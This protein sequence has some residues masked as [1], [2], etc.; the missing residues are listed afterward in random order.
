[1]GYYNW[2]EQV[3]NSFISMLAQNQQQRLEHRRLGMEQGRLALQKQQIGLEADR[4]RFE[5]DKWNRQ[6]ALDREK[7]KE[8]Q[9]GL[10]LQRQIFERQ[11]A[12]QDAEDNAWLGVPDVTLWRGDANSNNIMD[13]EEQ[14]STPARYVDK[15]KPTTF[16]LFDVPSYVNGEYKTTPTPLMYMDA[17]NILQQATNLAQGGMTNAELQSKLETDKQQQSLLGLQIEELEKTNKFWGGIPD[18]AQRLSDTNNDGL[19]NDL[20]T[21]TMVPAQFAHLTKGLSWDP[22][23]LNRFNNGKWEKETQWYRGDQAENFLNIYM[24][25]QENAAGT[26]EGQQDR[27]NSTKNAQINANASLARLNFEKQV[28]KE[29]ESERKRLRLAADQDFM[30]KNWS[31][32]SNTLYVDANGTLSYFKDR[33]VTNDAAVKLIQDTAN[34]LGCTYE[35]AKNL[36]ANS[37]TTRASSVSQ[38]KD[39]EYPLE[40]ENKYKQ[41]SVGQNAINT[42]T[43]R[44]LESKDV[45]RSISQ[46]TYGTYNGQA[47]RYNSKTRKWEV[48]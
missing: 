15:I 13:P 34:E 39:D 12:A 41:A 42:R 8:E 10:E 22:Y 38:K 4:N 21:P 45:S 26:W 2:G 19:Y 5:K 18:V 20:D 44:P 1:M 30:N 14:F 29:G 17:P 31:K 11:I 33:G 28:Y 9:I 32:F 43:G 3:G 25:N 16:G 23:Q 46:T 6:Y 36:I 7:W 27:I 48:A 37:L 40:G 35:Y 24:K 47:V